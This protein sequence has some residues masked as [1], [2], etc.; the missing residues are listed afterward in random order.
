MVPMNLKDFMENEV[1]K[2]NRDLHNLYGRK[3]TIDTYTKLIEKLGLDQTDDN[4][5]V[6]FYSKY[7]VVNG[8]EEHK[9]PEGGSDRFILKIGG[10][11]VEWIQLLYMISQAASCSKHVEIE[12][13]R[14]IKIGVM[15]ENALN[16]DP[17]FLIGNFQ[18]DVIDLIRGVEGRNGKVK[19]CRD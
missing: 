14:A 17:K 18:K 9:R 12:G 3:L 4:G 8:E 19:K 10:N 1:I 6:H 7:R 13:F 11:S 5:L 2:K 16:H 15:E